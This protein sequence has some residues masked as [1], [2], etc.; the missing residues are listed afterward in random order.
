VLDSALKYNTMITS[1]P[2]KVV[3]NEFSPGDAKVTLGGQ[4]TNQTEAARGFTLKIDFLD[5]AG[6]V[7]SSQS[8]DVP[9]VE[10]KRSKPFRVE[11]T[12]AGIVAFRYAPLT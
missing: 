9:A 1:I 12:G 4:V 10:A 2:A 3:F 11:G 5:K 7:V 6:N 8:V